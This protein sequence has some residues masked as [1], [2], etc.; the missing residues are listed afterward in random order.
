MYSMKITYDPYEYYEPTTLSY[1]QVEYDG[2]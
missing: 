2:R 1:L